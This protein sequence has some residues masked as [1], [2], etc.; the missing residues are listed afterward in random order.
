MLFTWIFLKIRP[1]L[2]RTRW[3][4][5]FITR[6]LFHWKQ[7]G[8]CCIEVS[9][10]QRTSLQII[11]WAILQNMFSSPPLPWTS[12]KPWAILR[13]K[14]LART[15]SNRSELI[16]SEKMEVKF[17]AFITS[18]G[19]TQRGND[20]F[21]LRLLYPGTDGTGGYAGS[22][23]GPHAVV[24]NEIPACAKIKMRSSSLK[25]VALLSNH[26]ADIP[27]LLSTTNP[28]LSLHSK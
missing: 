2:L 24:N 14:L 8:P 23:A 26:E 25:P 27:V 19:T 1:T 22:T 6:N 4:S 11:L 18:L 7:S 16:S 12:H 3:I 15:F 5:I 10:Y 9:W 21:T 28:R 17:R 13:V 20:S